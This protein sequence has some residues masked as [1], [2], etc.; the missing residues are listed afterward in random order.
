MRPTNSIQPIVSPSFSPSLD[1]SISIRSQV[2]QQGG[3]LLEIVFIV[4]FFLLGWASSKV[5]FCQQLVLPKTVMA[6]KYIMLARKIN[7][8]KGIVVQ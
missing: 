7:E 1:S 4:Y 6:A 8:N 2:N 5:E 3:T